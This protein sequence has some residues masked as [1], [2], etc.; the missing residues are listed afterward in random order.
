MTFRHPI[1]ISV[2]AVL[3]SVS[4]WLIAAE[5]VYSIVSGDWEGGRYH[6]PDG[7]FS[8]CSVAAQYQ[9]GIVLAIG[10]T[11]THV[12][13][14]SL[15]N[16]VWQLPVGEKYRIHIFVDRH[17][18]GVYTAEAT[19]TNRLQIS[20]APTDALVERLQKGYQLHVQAAKKDFYFKLTG[21]H[22]AIERLKACALAALADGRSAGSN[23]T[24][25]P[26][27]SDEIT[28]RYGDTDTREFVESMLGIA[29][30]DGVEFLDRH[31]NDFENAAAI[32]KTGALFGMLYDLAA[33]SAIEMR[34]RIQA[35]QTNLK[36]SCE[37]IY[38]TSDEATSTFGQYSITAYRAFCDEKSG[39]RFYSI[40]Y[41]MIESETMMIIHTVSDAQAAHQ[42]KGSHKKLLSTM[43]A[44]VKGLE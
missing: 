9:S 15:V 40:I 31:S 12:F 28:N 39:D 34:S 25:N 18:L 42:L 8:H 41:I 19:D 20:T 10:Y 21:T 22:R 23:D 32:W 1:K 16:D 38:S 26:F 43:I 24:D 27:S 14:L 2:F 33:D 13:G 17:D 5:Q 30:F 7:T 36:D 11:D 6:E 3:M 29:G 4:A 35:L 37:G 44:H